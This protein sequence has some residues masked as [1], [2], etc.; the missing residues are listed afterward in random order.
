MQQLVSAVGAHAALTLRVSSRAGCGSGCQL[1]DQVVVIVLRGSR[2]RT[3]GF[4][5]RVDCD[6]VAGFCAAAA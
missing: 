6:C 4:A 1:V 3:R 5:R 2:A